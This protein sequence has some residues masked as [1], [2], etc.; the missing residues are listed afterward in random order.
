MNLYY[1]LIIAIPLILT[2][3]YGM[4][5]STV[6]G[7]IYSNATVTRVE[8]DGISIKYSGG[9]S[10]L[11]FTNLPE[12]IQIQYGYDPEKAR[13]Y[14]HDVRKARQKHHADQ[15]AR[16]KR[17]QEL[18]ARKTLPPKRFT[19]EQ[20]NTFPEQYIGQRFVF[21][22][23]SISH[24]VKKLDLPNYY[25]LNLTSRSGEYVVPILRDDG[26]TFIVNKTIAE[27]MAEYFGGGF[28]WPNCNV[29]GIVKTYRI[30][31]E[32]VYVGVVSRIEVFDHDKKG[33]LIFGQ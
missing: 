9:I 1:K 3:T 32:T 11:A 25:A 8:P 31:N 14:I 33:N 27:K 4:D 5:I 2:T 23:C 24:D 21:T 6:S 28:K 30:R 12:P 7:I 13:T 20:L 26:I 29:F 17:Q 10:K 18:E 16:A 15:A 19:I 22:G